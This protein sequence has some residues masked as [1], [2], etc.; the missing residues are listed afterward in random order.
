MLSERQFAK[1]VGSSLSTVQERRKAKR[2]PKSA[3]KDAKGRWRIDPVKGLVEWEALAP[4][5]VGARG[6]DVPALTAWREARSRREAALAGL[7]EDELRKS[8]SELVNAAEMQ[9]VMVEAFTRAKSKLL[10][11]PTRIRHQCP[12][13]SL[14]DLAVLDGLIREALEDLAEGR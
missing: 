6:G 7:A 9:D 11:I 4:L 8:R 2:L 13:L 3:K 1:L 10:G 12:H 14:A 5:R